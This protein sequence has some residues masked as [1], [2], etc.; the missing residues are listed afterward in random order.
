MRFD[1]IVTPIVTPFDESHEVDFDRLADVVEFLI[2]KK[3]D[4]IMVAGTTGEFY[5]LTPE[6][7]SKTLRFILERVRGR[8]PV[9]AG[10]G[11][12]AMREALFHA[13]EA[14]TAGAQAVMIVSPSYALPVR[15]ENAAYALRIADAAGL[16]VMLYNFPGRTGADMDAEYLDI[17]TRHPGFQA[18]K[19]SS[20][21]IDRLHLLVQR[22]PSLQIACGKD[23]QALEFYAWGA[24]SWVCAGSNFTPEAHR[25][26]HDACVEGRDFARARRIMEA[27]LPLMEYRR[28]CGKFVQCI[29]EGMSIRGVPAG[30]TRLPQAPLDENEKA[31][32]RS[33]VSD[34][35][36][37]LAELGLE[38][39]AM[40]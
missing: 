34:M 38:E 9:I 39:D 36:R 23:D 15:K 25:L 30:N 19:E 13:E 35:N 31:E 27:M 5:A 22:Y 10:T 40:F 7:R 32:L 2:E 28:K 6:E 24:T 26:L 16:P 33:I 1:G 11:A 8:V 20:G 17:V 12:T 18:I 29:K 21:S 4:Q 14:K 3:A 37:K